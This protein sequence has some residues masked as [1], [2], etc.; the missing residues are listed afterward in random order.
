MKK[1][2]IWICIKP[3]P[4]LVYAEGEDGIQLGDGVKVVHINKTIPDETVWFT[5]LKTNNDFI[6]GRKVFVQYFSKRY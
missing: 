6:M 3:Y 1:G 4:P 2:E 5:L